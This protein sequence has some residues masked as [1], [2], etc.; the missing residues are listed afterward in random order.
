MRRNGNL[1]FLILVLSGLYVAVFQGIS[2]AEDIPVAVTKNVSLRVDGD[3]SCGFYVTIL[4]GNTAINNQSGCGEFSVWLQNAD[5]SVKDAVEN[6]KATE[7]KG[8]SS[9]VELTGK[10][11]L[12]Y[13]TDLW[14]TVTY[15]V[16]NEHVVRKRIAF[17]QTDMPVIFLK[18]TN[19]IEPAITPEKYW[20]F[21]QADCKGGYLRDLFP[22]IGYRTND[23]LTVGLLADAGFRN[24]YTRI[25]RRRPELNKEG[26]LTDLK[27]LPDARLFELCRPKERSLG[28]HYLSQT[29][30]EIIYKDEASSQKQPVEI[31]NDFKI[32]GQCHATLEDGEFRISGT[33]EQKGH[34]GISLP[35]IINEEGFY[36]VRF[37]YRSSGTLATRL[38]LMDKNRDVQKDLALAVDAI[39]ESKEWAVFERDF[40]IASGVGCPIELFVTRDWNSKTGKYDF[41]FKDIEIHRSKTA[42]KP[43]DRLTIGKKLEKTVFVFVDDKL[44][45]TLRDLRLASQIYLAEG[46]GFKG[47]QTEKVFYA[48]LMSLLWITEPFD[49]HPHSVPSIYYAPDMYNR[50]STI[51]YGPVTTAN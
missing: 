31:Q 44:R 35:V 6:W 29:F 46:L 18:T 40:G 14:I 38:W 42:S 20:S 8:D 16:I 34:G 4:A 22:A 21:D 27:E 3:K 9:H 19:R 23:G 5:A 50:D 51:L 13:V 33:I 37:K 25:F 1:P 49:F 48:T 32:H 10:S 39:P 41:A 15:D 47:G 7:W 30:G 43:F 45:D 17:Y 24:H 26:G 11:T 36:T 28:N 2:F 12:A